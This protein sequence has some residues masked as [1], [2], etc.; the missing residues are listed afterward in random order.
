MDIKMLE[1]KF[2]EIFAIEETLNCGI[3]LDCNT[4]KYEYAL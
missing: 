3:L 4:L 2:A 1:K